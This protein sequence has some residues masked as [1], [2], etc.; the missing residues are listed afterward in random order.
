MR[1]LYHHRTRRTGVEGVH[2]AGVINGLR[3]LGNEVVEVAMIREEPGVPE[4]AGPAERTLLKGALFRAAKHMPNKLFRFSELLYN[5]FAFYKMSK[6]LLSKKCDFIYERFAY[7]NFAGVV[8][9]RI[10]GI[11]LLLEVNIITELQDVRK[12][13]LV[14]LARFIEKKVI[15]S[16][17]AVFVVSAYLKDR[18]VARG[19]NPERI[20]V[21][22]NAFDVEE[23]CAASSADLAEKLLGKTAIG[24]LGR[25]LPWYKLDRL[26]KV[27]EAI[28][29]RKPETHLLFIGDGV[30]RT[31]LESM[32]ESAGLS[33]DVTFCGEAS[34]AEALG[35]LELLDI[36][37]I[38]STN[39]WGSPVKLLE[40]MGKGIPVVAPELDVVTSVMSDGL[41]GKTFKYDD[42]DDFEKALDCLAG[43]RELRRTMGQNGRRHIL[44]NHTWTKVAQNV[45]SVAE[46]I[47]ERPRQK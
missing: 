33:D 2:I 39:V 20:H 36:G 9:R 26:V 46:S 38:P 19:I 43:N 40:Y 47:L 8:A 44:E 7:F 3:R 28:H 23:D 10:F 4:I 1:I 11:P 31:L 22:P 41:H 27:F 21:Q 15:A 42:F 25:L 17:D 30:E 13:E 32:V 37:V 18:L 6:V 12:M 45:V 16:A 24:F 5:P 34:H 35:L 14:R 29:R